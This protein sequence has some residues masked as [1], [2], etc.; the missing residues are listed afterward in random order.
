VK[1]PR[2]ASA[3]G[4]DFPY[5]SSTTCFI[6]VAVDGTVTG[7]DGRGAYE[8]AVAGESRLYAVW[9]GQWSSDLF[10]IDDL[11]E[12]ARAVGLIHDEDRTGLARHEHDV[13]WA[14]S[15]YEDKPDGV[16][17]SIEVRLTCG[18]QI[19]DLSSFASHL[20]EQKGWDIA[21]SRGWGSS[22]SDEGGYC[23]RM[24]ARRTSLG[25]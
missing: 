5:R 1:V 25:S 20:R 17:I 21:T 18:C 23:Y 19:R 2:S 8:R 3:V 7:G 9:P 12:Y 16:Y 13:R 22:G 14:V 15:P 10:L 24:R 4:K 11:E 6:E